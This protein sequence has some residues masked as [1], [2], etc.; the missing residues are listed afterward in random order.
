[1]QPAAPSSEQATLEA[2]LSYRRLLQDSTD[3]ICD[4]DLQGEFTSLN[5]AAKELLGQDRQIAR[6]LSIFQAITDESHQ[7]IHDL[8][9]RTLLGGPC[10]KEDIVIYSASGDVFVWE[11]ASR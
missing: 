3:A 2:Q 4:L 1:V 9:S 8:L 10:R 7:A 11:L 6:E 5:A